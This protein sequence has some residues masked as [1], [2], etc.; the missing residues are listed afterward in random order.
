LA[1]KVVENLHKKVHGLKIL[2]QSFLIVF[3]RL[4]LLIGALKLFAL[5]YRCDIRGVFR[6]ASSCM[7]G[8]P[9]FESTWLT[10]VYRASE[11]NSGLQRLKI[12]CAT[13]STPL[14]TFALSG[15]RRET[16]S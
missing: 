11:R 12:E 14:L 5:V 15:V 16:R 7:N 9:N 1:G 8:F 6:T 10:S 3:V 13:S 2:L 4:Y